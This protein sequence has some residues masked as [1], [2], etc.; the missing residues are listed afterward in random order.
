MKASAFICR[1]ISEIYCII[2][3]VTLQRSAARDNSNFV[4]TDVNRSGISTANGKCHGNMLFYMT[5]NQF[6]ERLETNRQK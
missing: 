1:S 4:Y 2:K 3:C 5:V 6:V